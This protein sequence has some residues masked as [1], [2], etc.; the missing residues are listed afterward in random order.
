M[1]AAFNS[2][3][4]T[5]V[6]LA[7]IIGILV[8][9]FIAKNYSSVGGEATAV[10]SVASAWSSST[11]SKI[12][13]YAS[14]A[15]FISMVAVFGVFSGSLSGGGS[16]SKLAE[17][18]SFALSPQDKKKPLRN[19][20]V[21]MAYNASTVDNEYVELCAV[22]RLIVAGIRCLDF[23]IYSKDD[24]PVVGTSGTADFNYKETLNH[25]PFIDICKYLGKKIDG[26]DPYIIHLRMK[27]AKINTCNRVAAILKSALGEYLTPYSYTERSLAD[28]SVTLESLAGKVVVIVEKTA[29]VENSNLNSIVNAYSGTGQFQLYRAGSVTGN[30]LTMNYSKFAMILPNMSGGSNPDSEKLFSSMKCQFVGMCFYRKNN[31]KNYINN[32]GGSVGSGAGQAYYLVGAEAPVGGGE[33][34]KMNP[35][36][37]GWTEGEKVA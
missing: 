16:C 25:L 4:V 23:E 30:D 5:N 11:I 7:I 33:Y 8:V 32:F 27:T 31:L 26:G 28:D 15:A 36:P 21:A 12:L 18:P 35:P 29:T 20:R 3:K 34:P 14:L 13:F 22:E 9:F 17:I 10:A 24:E 1:S 6:F 37:K 19:Y 2:T